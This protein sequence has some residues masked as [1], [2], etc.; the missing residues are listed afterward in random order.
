MDWPDICAIPWDSRA[1]SFLHF[2]SL[3]FEFPEKVSFLN[4]RTK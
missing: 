2:D 1:S 3:F 4:E